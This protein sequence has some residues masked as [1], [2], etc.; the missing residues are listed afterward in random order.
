MTM[1]LRGL[2]QPPNLPFQPVE[3]YVSDQKIADWQVSNTAAFTIEI[4]AELTKGTE[5]L[6]LE[7]R[8]PKATSPKA[9]GINTDTRM[10][11]ICCYSI[12]LTQHP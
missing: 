9:L 10:L 2:V 6:N 8:I 5:T 3:V 4:P 1:T 7:F 11:G 12:E